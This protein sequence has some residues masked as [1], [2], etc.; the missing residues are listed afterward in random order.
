MKF[1][2]TWTVDLFGEDTQVSLSTTANQGESQADCVARHLRRVRNYLDSATFTPKDGTEFHTWKEIGGM[3]D[4]GVH[5]AVGSD[6]SA[7]LT[8]HTAS[9]LS[10][11]P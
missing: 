3:S 9:V 2:T 5:T 7:S 1:T 8:T 10:A 4:S 11:Y 6:W